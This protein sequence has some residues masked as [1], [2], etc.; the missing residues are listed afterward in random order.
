MAS[1]SK[2]H[3][4]AAIWIEKVINSCETPLQEIAARKL[5]QQ[6][7]IQYR[8]IDRELN[9]SLSKKLREA[10]DNKFYSRM[11]KLV[12]KIKNPE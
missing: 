9:F 1:T 3:G 8:D 6:F 11:D 10:L 4:D 2:H 7:E 5:T 12:E